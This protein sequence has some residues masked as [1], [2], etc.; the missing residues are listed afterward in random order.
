MKIQFSEGAF[1][2]YRSWMTKGT[3]PMLRRINT[4]IDNC[5][6][7]PFEG[8]GKPEPLRGD[9]SGLWSRRIDQEH[10]LIYTVASVDGEQV[11]VILGCRGHY[12]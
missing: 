6:R 9:L 8:I 5:V 1:D 11:L 3:I 4:L 2:E 7:T 12:R 10:R